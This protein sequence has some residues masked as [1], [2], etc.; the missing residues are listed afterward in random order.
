MT[1][2]LHQDA[3]LSIPGTK[4]S[5]TPV[6]AHAWEVYQTLAETIDGIGNRI[7][8]S[9]E[10]HRVHDLYL[11]AI[12][13]TF[14]SIRNEELKKLK[15]Q[16]EISAKSQLVHANARIQM[17]LEER[18]RHQPTPIDYDRLSVGAEVIVPID[19]I[20]RYGLVQDYDEDFDPVFADP[21]TGV[22]VNVRWYDPVARKWRNDDFALLDVCYYDSRNR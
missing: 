13:T 14:A 2:Q 15:E 10:M 9:D 16:T 6:E 11:S 22:I 4:T 21:S 8:P 18:Q 1:P 17:L 19:G 3:P 20:Y 7:K 12:Q 5:A